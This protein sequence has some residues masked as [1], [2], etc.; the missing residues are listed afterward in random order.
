MEVSVGIKKDGLSP[1]KYRPKYKEQH[2][3]WQGNAKAT[4]GK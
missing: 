4:S 2:E 1:A 3:D